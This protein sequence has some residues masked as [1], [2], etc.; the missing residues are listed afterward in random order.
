MRTGVWLP[1]GGDSSSSPY[2]TSFSSRIGDRLYW[3]PQPWIV[4][5]ACRLILPAVS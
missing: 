3:C 5:I 4:T 1:C 2:L